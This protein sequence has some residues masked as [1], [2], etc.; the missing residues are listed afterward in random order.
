MQ[1]ALRPVTV[2]DDTVERD[3]DDLNDELDDDADKGPVLA[4]DRD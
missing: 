3:T 1:L 4:R 2:K